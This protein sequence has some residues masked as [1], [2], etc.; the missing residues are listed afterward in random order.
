MRRAVGEL[1]AGLIIA[2]GAWK[3]SYFA[4]GP[5][6]E[7]RASQITD[8][9][10]RRVLIES[11]A[12]MWVPSLILAFLPIPKDRFSRWVPILVGAF[13]VV[14]FALVSGRTSWSTAPV[15]QREAYLSAGKAAAFGIFGSLVLTAIGAWGFSQPVPSR[16][17][18][19]SART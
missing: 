16:E 17:L 15:Q 8:A 6:F 18:A 4:W 19:E 11:M 7:F 13:G 3:V 12:M 14:V 2:W 9:G 5:E 1:I 10:L